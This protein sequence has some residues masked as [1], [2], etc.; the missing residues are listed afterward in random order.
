MTPLFLLAALAAPPAH[1]LT[2]A[3]PLDALATADWRGELAALA[4]QARAADPET[5]ARAAAMP[6]VP[7]RAGTLHMPELPAETGTIL[8]AE[9][10]VA[11]QDPAETRVALAIGVAHRAHEWPAIAVGLV[12]TEADPAVRAALLHGLRRV[13]GDDAL[14][15]LR[16]ALSDD[17]A[18]VRQEAL[19]VAAEHSDGAALH[20]ALLA[21]LS[22]PD[23][24]ARALAV[25][26][27]GRHGDA[28]DF[29]PLS[30]LLTDADT[31]VRYRTLRTLLR[32]APDALATSPRLPALRADPDPRIR[33][34]ATDLR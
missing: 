23:P 16:D 8:L 21:R 13:P 31:E 1:A 5:A 29:A 12:A 6:A 19:V 30:D 26:A 20:D 33:R 7:T 4:D 11:G 22:D 34:A 2:P 24:T 3:V 14:G 15:L 9:R 32:L 18:R 10:L 25:R 27:V 17:D 28:A